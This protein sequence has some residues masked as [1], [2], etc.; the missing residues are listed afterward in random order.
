MGKPE[1]CTSH[2]VTLPSYFKCLVKRTSSSVARKTGKNKGCFPAS[3]KE[4]WLVT[5]ST[6]LDHNISTH[7]SRAPAHAEKTSDKEL[8]GTGI[9]ENLTFFALPLTLVI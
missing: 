4:F 6:S 5:I 7:S 9:E 8:R 2:T 1:D 3:Q